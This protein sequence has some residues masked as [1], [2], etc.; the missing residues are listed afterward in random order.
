LCEASTSG[1]TLDWVVLGIGVNV[2]PGGALPEG[3]SSLKAETG[4][5]ASVLDVAAAVLRAVPA[6]YDAALD[7]RVA[8]VVLEWRRR[9]LPWWGRE[10]EVWSGDQR[11]HGVLRELDD[12]GALVIEP[13]AGP[14]IKVVSGD[15]RALRLQDGA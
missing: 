1:A 3:S 8:T 14:P 2:Q 9:S 15:V 13:P 6:W 12:S 4:R 11:L 5:A 10:V 7:A